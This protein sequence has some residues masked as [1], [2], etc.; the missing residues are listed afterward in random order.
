GDGGAATRRRR[1][2]ARRRDVAAE[3]AATR[4]FVLRCAPM[5]GPGLPPTT[6]LGEGRDAAGV[7]GFFDAMAALARAAPWRV[8]PTAAPLSVAIDELGIDGMVVTVV[9]QDGAPRG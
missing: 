5:S 6:Y 9:G 8:I 1:R 7:A 3:R 2:A 4:G